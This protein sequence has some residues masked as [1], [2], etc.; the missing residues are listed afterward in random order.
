M[1]GKTAKVYLTGEEEPL[2][3]VKIVKPNKAVEVQ[4]ELTPGQPVDF[5]ISL[6]NLNLKFSQLDHHKS[7]ESCRL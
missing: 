6:D 2:L 7:A 4:G 5:K 1:T 3:N